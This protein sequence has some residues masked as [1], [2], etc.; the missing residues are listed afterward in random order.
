MLDKML[1]NTSLRR[2]KSRNG[3]TL[4]EYALVLSFISVLS[5]TYLTALGGEIRGLFLS[6]IGSL[7]AAGHGF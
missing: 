1:R 2:L 3:Q 7:S 6:I 5:V 4:I